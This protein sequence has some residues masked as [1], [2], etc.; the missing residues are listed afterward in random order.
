M[1]AFAGLRW[2]GLPCLGLAFAVI[3]PLV[4]HASTGMSPRKVH[5]VSGESPAWYIRPAKYRR[6]TLIDA[7]ERKLGKIQERKQ[8]A[9]IDEWLEWTGACRCIE[10]CLRGI[11]R[12][13]L[14]IKR[15]L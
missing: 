2:Q 7:V 13:D 10:R 15:G 4:C 5:L 9:I 6:T 3:A 1:V 14:V 12:P 11:N 8:R